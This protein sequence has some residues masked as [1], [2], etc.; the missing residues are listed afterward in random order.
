MFESDGPLWV[1]SRH[2]AWRREWLNLVIAF[3]VPAVPFLPNI[4]LCF[5]RA[6]ELGLTSKTRANLLPR[7]RFP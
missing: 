6:D 1:G 7:D 2:S 3:S 5:G 4:G